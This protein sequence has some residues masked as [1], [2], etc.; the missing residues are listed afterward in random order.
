[1]YFVQKL[2]FSRK[3][4]RAA[5]VYLFGFSTHSVWDATRAVSGLANSVGMSPHPGMA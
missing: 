5:V 3:K 2:V 1:V 4:M